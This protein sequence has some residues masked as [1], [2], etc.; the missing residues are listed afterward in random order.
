M[1]TY[2]ITPLFCKAMLFFDQLEHMRRT[3]LLTKDIHHVVVDD[4]YPIDYKFNSQLLWN[5]AK[6][7]GCQYLN[8]GKGNRGMQS[9]INY[10]LKTI[11]PEDDDVIILSDVDDRASS[12]R[13]EALTRLITEDDHIAVAALSFDTNEQNRQKQMPK[14]V[15]LECN[16]PMNYKKY[17]IQYWVHPSVD[18]WH[19]AAYRFKWIKSIG[20]FD[21]V[22]PYWGGLES[23]LYSKFKPQGKALAYL[24]SHTCEDL[25][26]SF[27]FKDHK[28]FFDPEFK[29]Y[30]NHIHETQYKGS[31]SDWLNARP[32]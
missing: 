14:P 21:Q 10:A 22:Y 16:V 19:I 6:E 3:D 17:R 31:F 4:H 15:T 20:G 27:R 28:L 26:Q 1:K 2:V 5:F 13:Y 29:E 24:T 30:K 8:E 7:Y 32:V 12:G 23:Y 18:M 9:A 25:S 11:Q